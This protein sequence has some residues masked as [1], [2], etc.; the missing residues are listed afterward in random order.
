M[1]NAEHWDLCIT[2]LLLKLDVRDV[3][4][5]LDVNIDILVIV[6]LA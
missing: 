6:M 1:G 4:A 3:A 2:E 5:G